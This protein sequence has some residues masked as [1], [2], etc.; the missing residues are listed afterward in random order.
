MRIRTQLILAAF[1]LAVVPLAAIV[2]WS[3]HSS[4]RAL[5]LAYRQEAERQTRQMDRRLASIRTELEQRVRVAGALPLPAAGGSRED[6]GNFATVMGDAASLV[7]ALD[8]EPVRAGTPAPGAPVGATAP[9]ATARVA[10]PA[11]PAEP[12]DPSEPEE[13]PAA[14][15][16]TRRAPETP[17][18]PHTSESVV[19]E[20]PSTPSFPR[21]VVSEEHEE[22][23]T[24]ISELSHKLATE[25]LDEE[26]R[27]D[28]RRELAVTQRALHR[29]IN[30]DRLQFEAQLREAHAADAAQAEEVRARGG[31]MPRTPQIPRVR[32]F[33]RITP[34]PAPAASPSQDNASPARAVAASPEVNVREATS[35]DLESAA[36]HAR[37]TA[38]ILGRNFKVPV[39][40]Q[41]ELVGQLTARISAS[42][43][44]RRVLGAGDDAGGEIPFA[45]DRESTVYTRNDQ[46]RA[47]LRQLG[48]SNRVIEGR[49]VRDIPGW[50]VSVSTDPQSGLKFGVARPVSDNFGDIRK[51]A[52]QNFV[53]GLGLIAFALVG[54]VPLSNHLSRDVKLVTDGA[55]RIAHGDLMTRLP[56]KTKNEFGQLARAFNRMA[57]DLSLHQEKL[58]AQERAAKE[59]E[60]QQRLMAVEYERKSVELED[61]RRF[62]LS[63]LPKVVPQHAL[64][65]VAVFTRTATE[66]G[67]DYYDFHLLDDVLSVTIGDATGHGATAG[68]MVTVVKTLFSG[69]ENAMAPAAFLHDAEEKIRRMELG[70]MAMAL[71]LARFEGRRMRV[72]SAG[73]PP[74]LVHRA[75]EDAVEEL[76]LEATPLGTFGSEY[77]EREITLGPGDTVL[78]MTDGFP[79][80]LDHAGAQ[81]GYPG[82]LDAFSAAA[83]GSDAATVVEALTQ[84]VRTWHGDAP[85]N[86]DVTFVVVRVL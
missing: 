37:K 53:L 24:E 83:H 1:L 85:P 15:E 78:L 54:I 61:A 33:P 62:Q 14:G 21:F 47:K 22:L 13:P 4:R 70:R 11:E 36:A 80:L 43:V 66:V 81:L 58:V 30:E 20:I 3:Y 74:V 39:S 77:P 59:K 63:M 27:A 46:H 31:R 5:E 55:E 50:I 2:T 29:V 32:V 25:A 26:E 64:W 23:V 17:F 57:E 12:E 6:A 51:T 16:E 19:I 34:V 42:E 40:Q 44:I 9:R 79:E 65:N 82:A 8:F 86:D 84:S 73:M 68:T 49:S 75:A 7:D 41:G 76:A 69:Y 52:A 71:T 45:I 48:V 28:L 60:L 67:G 38:L 72:S 35:K 18:A 10:P 56:V